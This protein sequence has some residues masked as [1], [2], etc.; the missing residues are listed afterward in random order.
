MIRRV[1]LLLKQD[2]KI[3]SLTNYVWLHLIVFNVDQS[4]ETP[5]EGFYGL[6]SSLFPQFAC[7][8][9][10]NEMW[11]FSVVTDPSNDILEIE[12]S[13]FMIF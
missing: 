3:S 12:N 1:I 7:F 10:S 2:F 6:V 11:I 13:N 8:A 5:F 9:T 4:A